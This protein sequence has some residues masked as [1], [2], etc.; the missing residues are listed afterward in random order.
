[1]RP[2]PPLEQVEATLLEKPNDKRALLLA[3]R[4]RFREGDYQGSV[5]AA[6]QSIEGDGPAMELEL[7]QIRAHAA[8]WASTRK[9]PRS[10]GDHRKMGAYLEQAVYF[11]GKT[12]AWP[13]FARRVSLIL[14]TAG[15]HFRAN[16]LQKAADL[17][18]FAITTQPEGLAGKLAQYALAHIALAGGRAVEAI[19]L[20]AELERA[21]W[22]DERASWREVRDVCGHEEADSCCLLPA[23]PLDLHRNVEDLAF[24]LAARDPDVMLSQARLYSALLEPSRHKV[25][26]RDRYWADRLELS[27]WAAH[28]APLKMLGDKYREDGKERG[29]CRASPAVALA[30]YRASLDRFAEEDRYGGNSDVDAAHLAIAECLEELGDS[31]G[32]LGEGRLALRGRKLGEVDTKLSALLARLSQETLPPDAPEAIEYRRV[33]SLRVVAARKIQLR[34]KKHAV[35]KMKR[36]ATTVQCRWRGLRAFRKQGAWQD[37][38]QGSRYAEGLT[39]EVGEEFLRGQ[40]QFL[41]E[42]ETMTLNQRE[43]AIAKRKRELEARAPLLETAADRARKAELFAKRAAQRCGKAW[44][45][46]DAGHACRLDLRRRGWAPGAAQDWTRADRDLE[47]VPF[48]SPA[49]HRGK[50]ATWVKASAPARVAVIQARPGGAPVAACSD[51]VLAELGRADAL[52][53]R[54]ALLTSRD[55]I[56]IAEAIT[57]PAGPKPG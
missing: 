4:F 57:P 11:A 15:A 30:L 38:L 25:V 44:V 19:A 31:D 46:R 13:R 49:R 28:P 22:V 43:R 48:A 26:Q 34:H 39:G 5:A 18:A 8:W 52:I 6:Q 45:G 7:L 23:P 32:A 53:I 20:H 35:E 12:L 29:C 21:Y 24:R 10:A 33:A 54:R 56:R 3:A 9:G 50:G 16:N 41:V 37:F 27:V 40:R 36:A 42:L 1:M 17:V 47:S 2:D 55:V 14:E 51:D